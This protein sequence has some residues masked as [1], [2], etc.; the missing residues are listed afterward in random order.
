MEL[1]ELIDNL[2][3]ILDKEETDQKTGTITSF[4]TKSNDNLILNYPNGETLVEM[5][6][7]LGN[8]NKLQSFFINSLKKIIIDSDEIW[9]GQR[10]GGFSLG[11][12][13]TICF[14]ALVELGYTNE[15]IESLKKRRNGCHGIYRLISITLERNYFNSNQLKEISNKIDTD[16]GDNQSNKGEGLKLKIIQTRYELLKKQI[17]KVNI[18]INQDK[19]T[20]S[21]KINISRLSLGY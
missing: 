8:D 15:A 18:E 7:V 21:E 20:V 3:I 17:K 19:K 13:S 9:Y 16:R 11:G 1:D 12:N 5:F 10:G 2:K 6:S 14:Y 4:Y